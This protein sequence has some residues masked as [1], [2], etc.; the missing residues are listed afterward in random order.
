MVLLQENPNIIETAPINT[1]LTFQCTHTYLLLM[2]LVHICGMLAV[3]CTSYIW[4]C[5]YAVCEPSPAIFS[6]F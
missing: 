2:L 5:A 4:V 3:S 1:K 6:Y